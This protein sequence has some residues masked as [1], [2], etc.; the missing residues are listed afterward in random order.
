LRGLLAAPVQT[1]TRSKIAPREGAS[2]YRLLMIAN[3][4]RGNRVLRD[5]RDPDCCNRP[6]RAA[7]LVHRA[8]HQPLSL[9]GIGA[10]PFAATG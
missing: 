5:D 3:G 10:V 2:S 8:S 9:I 4:S 6:P 1:A 7:R